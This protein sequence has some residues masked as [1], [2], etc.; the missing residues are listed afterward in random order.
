[1]I[2]KVEIQGYKSIKDLKIDLSPINLL[3]GANGVGKTNF[4]SFFVMLRFIYIQSL[5]NY[6]RR[7]GGAD[8]LLHYGRKSTNKLSGYI[9]FGANAYR[10]T[11]APTDQNSLFIE[12]E[13]SIY[14]PGENQYFYSNIEE[15][16]IKDSDTYRDKWLREGLNSYLRYHFHDTGIQSPMRVSCNVSD[17]AMLYSNGSNLPAFLFGLQEKAP[18]VLSRI[19]RV[20][21]T[22][23]PGFSHFVLEPREGGQIYLEWVEDSHE[24]KVFFSSDLSDGSLRFIALTTLLM[25]PQL[26]PTI[27]IDEPELGLHPVAIR[28]LAGLMKSAADRGCQLIVSTQSVELINNFSADDI[29]TVDRSEGQSVFHRLQ[30]EELSSWLEDYSI[31]ELWNKSIINGQP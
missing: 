28:T 9:E 15:S 14:L 30:T 22:V 3:I 23:M 13:E 8:T 20:V 31:G 21:A 11:L 2:R 29:I 17:S 24:D 16:R 18:K 19:E 7:R 10:F 6:V 27:I 12:K 26:P 5:Q 4:L 1:M 25:Q